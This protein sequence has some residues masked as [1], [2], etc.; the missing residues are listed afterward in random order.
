MFRQFSSTSEDCL[1]TSFI[2]ETRVLTALMN[3]SKPSYLSGWAFLSVMESDEEDALGFKAV[4]HPEGPRVEYNGAFFD[5]E[6]LEDPSVA[7]LWV[8]MALHG[9]CTELLHETDEEGLF[10]V[11][12]WREMRETVC[13][14]MC[15]TW[16]E[17]MAATERE[18]VRYMSET[19]ASALFIESG[20][21]DIL[22]KRKTSRNSQLKSA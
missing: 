10:A 22:T 8:P 15:M 9:L 3:E 12:R 6:L 19:L 21:M 13:H 20:L 2:D 4:A 16:E 1:A 14:H 11:S 18:G 7:L 5:A 17:I